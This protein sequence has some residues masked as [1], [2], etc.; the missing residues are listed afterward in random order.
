MSQLSDGA[1]AAASHAIE[2]YQDHH[3]YTGDGWRARCACGWRSR[4]LPTER[5]AEDVAVA[6]IKWAAHVAKGG[7]SD[8]A[9]DSV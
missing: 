9:G 7:A 4:W 6:H 8:G 3:W 5:Q 1:D 2:T